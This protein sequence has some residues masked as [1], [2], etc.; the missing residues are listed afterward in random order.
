MNERGYKILF[1]CAANSARSLMTD[2]LPPR[3]Q[4]AD[5]GEINT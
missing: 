3:W 4:L 1:L 5:I 2:P